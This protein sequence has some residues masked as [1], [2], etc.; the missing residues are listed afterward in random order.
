M[1]PTEMSAPRPMSSE[2]SLDM[3]TSLIKTMPMVEQNRHRPEVN[4]ADPVPSRLASMASLGA[5]F[6]RS[7]R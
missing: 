4:M 1:T 7:S 3:F 2:S 6:W 5:C